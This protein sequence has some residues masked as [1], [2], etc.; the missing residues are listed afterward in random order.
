MYKLLKGHYINKD[1]E[2]RNKLKDSY[3]K[4]WHRFVFRLTNPYLRKFYFGG[5]AKYIR[6]FP[7]R[8][9]IFANRGAFKRDKEITE[10]MAVINAMKKFKIKTPIVYDIGSG[11]GF[12]TQLNSVLNP[13]VFTY[14]I[15]DNEEMRVDQFLSTPRA[16]FH[17]LDVY[18]EPFKQ[19]IEF[20]YGDITIVGVHLCFDLAAKFIDIFNEH[21]NIKNM[22]L[23][24][25]CH[26]GYNYEGWMKVL[27]DGIDEPD[28]HSYI[29]KRIISVRD[30][31]IVAKRK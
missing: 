8:N 14:A 7:K 2:V 30:G 17:R 6:R 4:K 21:L 15:D 20:T 12:F 19:L 3:K 16:I 13:E 11:V 1:G 28:K 26:K 10:A 25:C 9:R 27:Y 18:D 23:L 24:P 31:V 5:I 22:I 29:D